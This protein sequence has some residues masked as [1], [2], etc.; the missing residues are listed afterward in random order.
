MKAYMLRHQVAGIVTS[1][2][3]AT[4]PTEAQLAPLVKECERLHGSDHKGK[5]TWVML[6]EVELLSAG[7]VPSLPERAPSSGAGG[8]GAE[9]KIPAPSIKVIGTVTNPTE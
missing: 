5:K 7:E 9:M 3:F 1:H 4:K 8:P 2:V 6:H